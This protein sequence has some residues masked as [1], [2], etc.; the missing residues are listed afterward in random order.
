MLCMVVVVV[1]PHSLP[2]NVLWHDWLEDEVG[3][4]ASRVV[5]CHHNSLSIPPPSPSCLTSGKLS[6]Q[7]HCIL[8]IVVH[9]AINAWHRQALSWRL[10]PTKCLASGRIICQTF[11]QLGDGGERKE[12]EKSIKRRA[13]S[14]NY[15]YSSHAE[16]QGPLLTAPPSI[17][18][19]RTLLQLFL[20]WLSE[21]SQGESG[22]H[23][24]KLEKQW[25]LL[26]SVLNIFLLPK[27]L[28]IRSTPS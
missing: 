25:T 9:R 27:E 5:K 20:S 17:I 28:E 8:G 11:R 12:E 15:L 26:Q 18:S 14:L 2:P 23:Q 3:C 7:T 4:K 13:K 21:K 22:Y 10:Q 1:T 24:K 19:S 16:G 6:S